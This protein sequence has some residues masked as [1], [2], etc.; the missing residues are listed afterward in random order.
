MK[1]NADWLLGKKFIYQGITVIAGF[2][3]ALNQGLKIE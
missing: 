3:F 2:F 1:N